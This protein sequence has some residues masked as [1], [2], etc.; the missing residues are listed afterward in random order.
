MLKA[1]LVMATIVVLVAVGLA[2]FFL[3]RSPANQ[4]ELDQAMTVAS[5]RA[6]EQAR[7]DHGITLD[8]SPESVERVEMILGALHDKHL[9]KPFSIIE[10]GNLAGTWGAYIGEAAKRT[11]P[12]SWTNRGLVHENGEEVFPASW[13]HARISA[14]PED[15]VWN[16]FQLTYFRD[17]F[18]V[19]DLSTLDESGK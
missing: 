7:A 11:R 16:K 3:R 9:K 19:L 5:S 15:N 6:V 1:I 18:K 8:G 2:V 17:R 14:G 4:A 10:L 12:G 13:V